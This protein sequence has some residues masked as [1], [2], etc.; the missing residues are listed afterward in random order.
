[1]TDVSSM[2]VVGFLWAVTAV[3]WL[4]LIP[5]GTRGRA[6]HYGL[7]AAPLAFIVL[8]AAAPQSTLR[9]SLEIWILP[10]GAG[11]LG[12]MAVAWLWGTLARNHGVM[13]ICYPAAAAA[14]AVLTL[15]ASGG[16][17]TGPDLLLM[18]FL[19][20]GAGRLIIQTWGHN[21]GAERQPYA[22][23]RARHGSRWLWWSAFQVH[24]LQGVTLWLWSAPIVFALTV[25]ASVSG[26]TR[27]GFAI[28][29]VVVWLG[30][31]TLQTLADRQLAAFKAIPAN[32]GRLLDTGVWAW[33]RHPNY[34]GE[35]LMWAA[36][37]IFALA[38]PWG[39]ITLFAPLFT[40]WFMGYASAAPFKEAHMVRTRGEAWTAYCARTPR[41]LPWPRPRAVD[42]ER[43][44]S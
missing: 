29:G 31:F 10:G 5:A 28:A 6:W 39:W 9:D 37:F 18:V 13:D 3:L 11:V 34:L 7:A 2:G 42:P 4:M 16:A 33:V 15:A 32:R 12:V 20:I 35:T 14:V 1:M 30:G 23:W 27:W 22:H 25:P 36:W 21:V 41:F 19:V 38:H 17:P 43:K 24:L 40:G 26:T 44:P 8:T